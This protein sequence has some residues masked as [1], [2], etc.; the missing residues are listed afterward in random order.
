MGHT[1]TPLRGQETEAGKIPQAIRGAVWILHP[2][3]GR[4]KILL[5]KRWGGI[6]CYFHGKT[7]AQADGLSII[8][9]MVK[10]QKG[11]G[12]RKQREKETSHY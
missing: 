4:S 2:K 7:E 10:E 12:G 9:Q 8:I 11:G 3:Q 5:R 1:A 6:D